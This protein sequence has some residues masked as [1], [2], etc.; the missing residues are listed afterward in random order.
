MNSSSTILSYNFTNSETPFVS[1]M[2]SRTDNCSGRLLNNGASVKGQSFPKIGFMELRK[3]FLR[4][5]KVVFT[6]CLNSFSSH[7]K[8]STPFRV[9]R[10]TA[11]FT[12]GGGLNT[13]SLTVNRYSTLYHA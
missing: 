9:I 5:L 3:V 4:W 2:N 7:P 8:S 11:L 13:C 6:T 10:I 1:S 12:L